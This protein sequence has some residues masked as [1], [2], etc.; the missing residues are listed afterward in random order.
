M[1]YTGAR[2]SRTSGINSGIVQGQDAAVQGDL[3]GKMAPNFELDTLDGKKIKLSDLRGKAVLVNFW[4]TWCGPCKIEMPW[5]VE[6]QNQYGTE[7]LTIIGIAMDDSPT[8]E[9]AKFAKEMGVNYPILRGKEALGEAYGGVMGL[10]TTFYVGR[11]G[12]IVD[13]GAGL[14]SR[15]EIENNIKA[16]LAQGVGSAA[17][18]SAEAP[19]EKK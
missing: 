19:R 4:A 10:P 14:V 17:V 11:D 8:E 7:G 13:Q 16:A 1:I 9:I 18:A 6:L 15:K 12:K 3:K 5:F 2:K